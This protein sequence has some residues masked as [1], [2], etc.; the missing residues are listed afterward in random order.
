MKN[1]RCLLNIFSLILIS[2]FLNGQSVT[3][4]PT[5][6]AGIANSLEVNN[7]SSTAT[8]EFTNDAIELSNVTLEV[9]LGTG[10]VYCDGFKFITSG[11]AVVTPL[12]ASGDSPALFSI[13]Q[14]EPGE[15]VTIIFDRKAYCEA[16]DH[17]IAGGT[18]EDVLHVY[19]SGTEVTYSNNSNDPF[20]AEY[21][22]T[23]GN[24]IIGAVSHSPS[25]T[26]GIGETITR[27]FNVTNGSFG[28]IKEFWVSDTF[29]LGE[30]E[31]SNYQ[32]NG[33]TIPASLITIGPDGFRIHFDDSIIPNI[34]S[35][36]GASGDG[37]VFFE[38]DEFFQ[39]SYDI[40]L[41][42]CSVGN[43]LPS[44]IH[45]YYGEDVDQECAPSGRNSTSVSI[46]NGVPELTVAITTFTAPDLC[47]AVQHCVTITNTATAPEDFAMDLNILNGEGHN[48]SN[49]ATP[50]NNSLESS[51]YRLWDNFMIND[52]S[53]VLANAPSGDLN[54]PYIGFDVYTTNVDGP[55]GLEDLDMDGF[56]DDLGAGSSIEVCFD[57]TLT[58]EDITCGLGRAAGIEWQHHYFD[59]NHKNQCAEDRTPIRKDLHYGS[60]LR[61]YITPTIFAGPSDV[62]DKDTFQVWVRPYMRNLGAT[63]N[64]NGASSTNSTN[65]DVEFTVALALPPGIS[66]DNNN[67]NLPD[68]YNPSITANAAG[69]TA[70]YTINRTNLAEDRFDF[71]LKFDCEVWDNVSP[72]T[73]PFQTTYK[74]SDCYEEEVHCGLIEII[75]HCPGCDFGI[76]TKGLTP[77]RTTAGYTDSSMI[78][79]V[80]LT[81]GTHALDWLLP[82]DTFD[83]YTP[84]VISGDDTEN[85]YYRLVYTP[86]SGN[87]VI[88]FVEGTVTFYDVDGEFGSNYHTVPIIDP[89]LVTDLGNGSFEALFNLTNSIPLVDPAYVIG[90][91]SGGAGTYDKDSVN[92]NLSF[93][94]GNNFPTQNI[95]ELNMRGTHFYLDDLGNEIFCDNY[96]G[97]MYYEYPNIRF[98]QSDRVLSLGCE[99]IPI[100]PLLAIGSATADPFPDEYRP[101][102]RLDSIIYT[103]PT[104][105]EFTGEIMAAGFVSTFSYYYNTDGDLVVITNPDYEIHDTRG[106]Y[107][108]RPRIIV[109]ANCLAESGGPYTFPATAFWTNYLYADPVN[110]VSSSAS[111]SLSELEEYVAPSFTLTPLNQIVQGYSDAIYWDIQVCNETATLDVDYTW[112]AIKDHTAGLIIDSIVDISSGTSILVDTLDFGDGNTLVQ[113]GNL[114]GATCKV[115]RIYSTYSSCSD[116]VLDIDYGWSCA[117]YPTKKDEVID[118]M[119]STTVK[120]KDQDA[121]ISATITP[122]ADSPIDPSNPSAGNYNNTTIEI[123]EEFPVEVSFIS[124]DAGTL[125]D[126]DFNVL[127]PNGGTGLE[128]VLGSGTI[129]V[130]GIDS[131]DTP[132]TWDI[133]ADTTFAYSNGNNFKIYLEDID[134]TNFKEEG[135]IGAGQ[136]PTRNEFIL[137]WKMKSTCSLTS[138]SPFRMRVFAYEQCG[139]RA[140]GFGE[141]IK[142]SN[143]GIEGAVS[144]YSTSMTTTFSPNNTFSNCGE[145]KNLALDVFL[146]GGTTGDK[147][148]LFVYLPVGINYEGNISCTSNV[149]PSYVETRTELDQEVI[150]FSYP[151]GLTNP[152]FTFNFDIASTLDMI[153]GAPTV[154]VLSTAV[155]SG[156]LCDGVTCLNSKVI[157]GNSSLAML[158]SKPLLALNNYDA[159]LCP[160]TTFL[161]IGNVNL[162]VAEGVLQSSDAYKIDF[163]CADSAGDAIGSI[164][165]SVE[166]NGP[167]LMGETIDFSTAFSFV[168]CDADNGVVGVISNTTSCTCDTLLLPINTFSFSPSVEATIQDTTTCPGESINLSAFTKNTS[169]YTWSPDIAINCTTCLNPI[170]NPTTTQQY[171]ITE[172]DDLGCISK[173]T[174]EVL[175]TD[176]DYGD[177]PDVS[178]VLATDDYQTL[179]SSN[180]PRHM[181]ISGLQLGVSVDGE[182]DGN[183]SNDA[184]GDGADEDGLA[185][186][187]SLDITPNSTFRLPL[188]VINTTGAIAHLEAWIDWNGDGDFL[189]ANEMPIDLDDSTGF[190]NTLELTVPVGAKMDS[191]LGIRIRLSNTNNMSPYGLIRSGEVE[192]YL[193]QIEC[194][195][196]C[197]PSLITIQKL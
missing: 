68:I 118:C 111:N 151:V 25:A 126:I 146:S 194:N 17:K 3:W 18:F 49:I 14:L 29:N 171:I 159:L 69:D 55:G 28:G 31:T 57:L 6:P 24:I 158:I 161:T 168:A 63:I 10:V 97:I 54:T 82:Y 101:V 22:V 65:L 138:N 107:Y 1:P 105:F 175:I 179:F 102:Y 162:V 76:S 147:D 41:L 38:K 186:F 154:E 37:D 64:C 113:M 84:G 34:N 176:C 184:L 114:E 96:G 135:L 170:V 88:E 120:V 132:R 91:G 86:D 15:Q 129:E 42:S 182:L 46:K 58:P 53:I 190:P 70:F 87:D 174:V 32:I 77:Q 75:P 180:G 35:F 137:R 187:P 39:L 108:P 11:S 177:L 144:P 45:G 142:S 149:C 112:L 167:A 152:R 136:D 185:F 52:S 123:C 121:T 27:N 36:I 73:L 19:E 59:V 98:S 122:L 139:E 100:Q 80:D 47:Y 62:V 48:T 169:Q 44:E 56:Y 140:G 89:P 85:V 4:G 196:V 51:I 153:C 20:S 188:E 13:D 130:E 50:A 145:T 197:L 90:K 60:L 94:L 143:Y 109:K 127:L 157:T 181:I 2:T 99:S 172:I 165:D 83:I 163:Y 117:G 110:Q 7:G 193:L 150:V 26:A 155:I 106:T 166:I 178:T 21:D 173:D 119:Q 74:C 128:Y 189:D 43:S 81:D 103:L 71:N 9:V 131:T 116:E 33:V 30:I 156:L 78:A 164:L 12:S 133:T 79:M 104:E 183:P 61:E 141:I 195:D 66:L 134:S 124:S 92:L 192:D 8:F 148:S 95:Q 72:L 16:R 40:T 67:T 23:Y 191:L 5:T 160:D 93:I 115:M 125:H